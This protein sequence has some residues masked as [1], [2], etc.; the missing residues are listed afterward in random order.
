M[1]HSSTLSQIKNRSQEASV[2]RSPIAHALSITRFAVEAAL[3]ARLELIKILAAIRNFERMRRRG[4]RRFALLRQFAS[5]KRRKRNHATP[6]D[7]D[8]ALRVD[9]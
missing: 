1:H 5:S 2:T 4:R 9:Q 8:G 6:I 7:A 3:R